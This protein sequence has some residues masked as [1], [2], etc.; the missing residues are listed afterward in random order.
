MPQG[1]EEVFPC[2]FLGGLGFE[3]IK[4]EVVTLD[5]GFVL[6]EGSDHV[7]ADDEAV[8]VFFD[9]CRPVFVQQAVG[10]RFPVQR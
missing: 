6:S 10:E 1:G 4:D 7:R 2:N 9:Q 3:G 8:G 5:G